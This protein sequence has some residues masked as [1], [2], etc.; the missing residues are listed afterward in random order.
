MGG[1]PKVPKPAPPPPLPD[2]NPDDAELK[3]RED[4]MARRRRG[5]AGLIA[6]S[7]KGIPDAPSTG[8]SYRKTLLGE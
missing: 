7:A 4:A 8:A 3:A 5:L 6:T 1:S 2:T